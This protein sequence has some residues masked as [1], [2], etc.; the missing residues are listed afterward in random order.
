MQ[1]DYE[2]TQGFRIVQARTEA[3]YPTAA[4]FARDVGC[5]ES[6]LWK[7]EN[8]RRKPGPEILARM[9]ELTPRSVYWII[10]G[11]ER[12]DAPSYA[13]RAPT[14]PEAA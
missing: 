2:E 10:T 5:G 14:S 3:G 6:Q 9:S 4:S 7:Y 8:N 11:R 1:V 13:E 12:G